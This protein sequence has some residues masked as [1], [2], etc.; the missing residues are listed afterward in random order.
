MG[1]K[2]IDGKNFIKRGWV[3]NEEKKCQKRISKI[4]KSVFTW[5]A[6]Q[7]H[8]GSYVE[9][10]K[11]FPILGAQDFIDY[12]I[13]CMLSVFNVIE[14]LTKLEDEIW[15]GTFLDWAQNFIFRKKSK[16]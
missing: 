11:N 4:P 5:F 16:F 15:I 3:K 14:L 2:K 6:K 9:S 8:R 12:Q 10:D 7:N 1:K 13:S